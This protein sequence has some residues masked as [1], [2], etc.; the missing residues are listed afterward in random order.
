M[1]ID[2][3][4]LAAHAGLRSFF[5]PWSYFQDMIWQYI[6]ICLVSL[7]L[8]IYANDHDGEIVQWEL[9]WLRDFP[10][11]EPHANAL[12]SEI[13]RLVWKT[14]KS[15]LAAMD[16]VG[17]TSNLNEHPLLIFRYPPKKFTTLLSSSRVSIHLLFRRWR[18]LPFFFFNTHLWNHLHIPQRGCFRERKRKIFTRWIELGLTFFPH[19]DHLSLELDPECLSHLVDPDFCLEEMNR[20]YTRWR[21]H[22]ASVARLIQ[23][24]VVKD[25]THVILS[26]MFLA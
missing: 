21:Y 18:M 4:F 10:K 15:F 14:D 19:L 2:K 13:R 11:S 23:N 16:R 7:D 3:S 1:S 9:G 26:Y 20:L 5:E 22:C 17:L 12:L 25:L 6:A 24:A 8:A